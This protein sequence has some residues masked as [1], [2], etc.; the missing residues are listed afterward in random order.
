MKQSIFFLIAF[1]TVTAFNQ[2]L[3]IAGTFTS[4]VAGV[5]VTFN[6][7]STFQYVANDQNPM[8][9]KSEK[10]SEKGRWIIKK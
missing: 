2:S 4:S 1:N 9:Y 3:H 7:D 10:L 8:F 5:M 6:K